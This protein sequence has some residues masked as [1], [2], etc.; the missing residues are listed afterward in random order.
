MNGTEIRDPRPDLSL[1]LAEC[2]LFLSMISSFEPGKNFA[3]S[4]IHIWGSYSPS[5]PGG[6]R[7]ELPPQG[8]AYSF[9]DHLS[10]PGRVPSTPAVLIP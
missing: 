8:D 2:M 4:K 6:K 5:V 9:H 10:S 1:V 3:Y 7:F